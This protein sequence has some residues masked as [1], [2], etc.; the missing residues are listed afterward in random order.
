L[1]FYGSAVAWV[2]STGPGHRI[3]LVSI[4]GRP[5]KRI[6]LASPTASARA[7]WSASWGVAGWHTIRVSVPP[8]A[9]GGARVDVD[10]FLVISPQATPVPTI[11]AAGL[12]PVKVSNAGRQP[13]VRQVTGP[14]TGSPSGGP[15]LAWDGL[16]GG[17]LLVFMPVS[18]RG[19]YRVTV[20]AKTGPDHGTI[21]IGTFGSAAMRR[22]ELYAP[23]DG[24]TAPVDIGI[25]DSGPPHESLSITVTGKD[26]RSTGY[27]VELDSI[28]LTPVE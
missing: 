20:Y 12:L 21:E 28:V 3:G 22:L 13:V 17:E 11:L 9:D 1:R 26:P 7:V 27:A 25:V 19:R 18:A 24:R 14:D 4:D 2:S 8:A 16:P 15:G 5:D 23:R 6:G 10:A